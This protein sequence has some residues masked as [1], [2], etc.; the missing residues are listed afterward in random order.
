[1]TGEN[2]RQ[3]LI[4]YEEKLSEVQIL[5]MGRRMATCQLE[6]E[7]ISAEAKQKAAEYKAQISD[8]VNEQNT[9]AGCIRSGVRLQTEMCDIDYNYDDGIVHF[10]NNNGVI[11]K[12][13]QMTVEERQL[14][15]FGGKE[16][17]QAGE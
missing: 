16:D 14:P 5:E 15:L 7:K 17:E 11:V 9:L 10:I 4:E 12:S 8:K 2:R 1:M 6:A 3:S 13:R